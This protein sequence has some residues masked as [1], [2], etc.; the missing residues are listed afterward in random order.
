[1]F[2]S[3]SNKRWPEA[4]KLK[5]TTNA[6]F[7]AAWLCHSHGVGFFLTQ[8]KAP[9]YRY[10]RSGKHAPEGHV[11]NISQNMLSS[12]SELLLLSSLLQDAI[13]SCICGLYRPRKSDPKA[14]YALTSPC[15]NKAA[16]HDKHV[17]VSDLEKGWRK[18]NFEPR[19]W[20]EIEM[21]TKSRRLQKKGKTSRRTLLF[22]QTA[23][24]LWR[25]GQ[26]S[27]CLGRWESVVPMT[28]LSSCPA[29]HGVGT[30]SRTVV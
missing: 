1:M 24:A 11:A 14:Y 23:H 16:I 13:K 12:F 3:S 25:W 9:H 19:Q 21:A 6:N 20:E 22:V 7:L 29:G 27:T 4:K 8:T 2:F 28:I 17:H 18:C 15:S 26:R 5:S 10:G 30:L